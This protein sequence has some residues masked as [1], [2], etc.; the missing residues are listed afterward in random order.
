[1]LA[2]QVWA[3]TLPIPIPTPLQATTTLIFMSIASLFFPILLPLGCIPK[4]LVLSVLELYMNA[5]VQYIHFWIWLLSLNVLFGRFICHLAFNCS[6]FVFVALVV[7]HMIYHNL[8][9]H[10]SA[11]GHLGCFQM[12]VVWIVLLWTFWYMSSDAWATTRLLRIGLRVRLLSNRL[13]VSTASEN[14]AKLFSNM[15]ILIYTPTSN[16]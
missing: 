1:M 7:F 3:A 15:F 13:H 14:K 16:M 2:S 9:T 12:E 6:W 4:Y 11:D 8:F 5:T 10:P